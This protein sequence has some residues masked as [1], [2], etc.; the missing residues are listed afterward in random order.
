MPLYLTVANLVALLTIVA[1]LL[2]KRRRGSKSRI[3][4]DFVPDGQ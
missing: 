1:E 4:E 2:Q 3:V